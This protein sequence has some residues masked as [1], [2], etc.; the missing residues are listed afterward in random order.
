MKSFATLALVA[1]AAAS[2]I[3]EERQRG[4]RVGSTATEFTDGG[5]KDIIMLFARGST[6]T[7][8]MGT[9]CGP[10]T[11]NAVK[12]AFGAD[13]VAVEGIEYA[14]ALS[15]N[16]GPGGADRRGIAEMERLIAQANTD[17]PNSMLV[18]GGYSQGAALTHRAVEDLPQAQKDQ[19]V[20]AFTFGDT[21]NQQDNGQIPNFP[22]EKTNVIC[23]R[24][25]AV[26]SGTLNI[27]PPHLQYGARADEQAQF[28]NSKLQAAGA[29]LKKRN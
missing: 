4:G 17:C 7:G 1:L 8:N 9:I 15:T 3:I 12:A 13:K 25:D 10:Q 5:C 11:A 14:A 6:E 27:L 16:F 22:P 23:N 20:A 28:I 26:C 18:V 19:I 29:K 24:G 2:P 21:Q